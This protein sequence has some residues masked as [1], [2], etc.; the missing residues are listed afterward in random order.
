MRH[1]A[2]LAVRGRGPTAP[3]PCVGAVLV[4]DGLVVAEGWHERYGG[5]HA[6]VNCLANARERGVDPGDCALFV[7]LEPCNHQGKTPPCS[8]AVYK[9]GVREVYVGAMDPTPQAGGGAAWLA[10]RGVAVHTGVEE[11]LCRDLIAD[12]L[13]WQ[14]TDRPYVYLKLAST[15]DGRIATR[16]GHSKWITCPESRAEVHA[17]RALCGAVIVGGGTFRA[18]D[19]RLNVRRDDVKGADPLAVVV[20]G[21]LPEARADFFL[22]RERPTETIFWTTR[23]AAASDAARALEKRGVRVWALPGARGG[24]LDLAEGLARLRTECGVWHALC[25][26]GGNLA[27]RF[28]ESG[29]MDEFQ[30]YVA[31]KILGDEQA[32]PLFSGR[33]P[34]TMDQALGL[35]LADVRMSGEDT[36]LTLRPAR[37]D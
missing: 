31:P 20:T 3:N 25:E 19:P 4:R 16:S 11:G 21:N 29:L 8:K 15:L 5:P 17:L 9:A 32:A 2:E 22:L 34:E 6:E 26:G 36:L 27:L 33:A 7:T 35:R 30:L 23:E 10:E 24:G 37:E 1:A 13:A 14:A 12:F 28:V 18:D